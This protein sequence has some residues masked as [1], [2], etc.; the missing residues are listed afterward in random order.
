M[1]WEDSLTPP[2]LSDAILSLKPSG[3]L[4]SCEQEPDS[5]V[6]E[7]GQSSVPTDEAVAA[8]LER[9]TALWQQFDYRRNRKFEYPEIGDQ[10]DALFHAGVFP[11]S[12]AE[13]I[14]A[15]KDKYPKPEAA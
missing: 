4:F 15:I 10:L 7:E 12:M 6:W 3:A 13:K 14:Q 2:M 8:E 5:I 9:I 1:A 11:D